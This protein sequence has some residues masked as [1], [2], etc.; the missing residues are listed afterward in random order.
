MEDFQKQHN[1]DKII[2]IIA[3]LFLFI[4]AASLTA[5]LPSLGSFNPNNPEAVANV[6][7]DDNCWILIAA[8]L[9]LLMTPGVAFFYGGAVYHKNVISTMYQSFIFCMGLISVLW[10]IIGFSL[11]FGEDAHHS[12]ILG[13]PK[14]YY[15]FNNVGAALNAALASNIS[16]TTF[17]MF[18]FMF[19]II[20][21]GLIAG[22]LAERVHFRSWML[23]VCFWYLVVCCPL[24]HITWS[25]NGILK[26]WGYI[27]FTGGILV[28]MASGYATLAG[29]LF[30]GPR[31]VL[32][33][34]PPNVPF[35]MLSTALFWFGW[36]GFNAG[37][38]LNVEPIASQVFLAT[39]TSGMVTWLLLDMYRGRKTS[40]VG[41]CNGI[42][43]GL[44]AII[45]GAGYVTAGAAMC[46]GIIATLICLCAGVGMKT[47]SS[48]DDSLDVFTVHGLSGTIGVILTGVFASSQVNPYGADGAIYGNP[49]LLA[50]HVA[51]VVL[52]IPPCIMIASYGCFW[53][54][55]L[56]SPMRVTA[57]EEL[58]GLDL[59]F[60]GESLHDSS[61]A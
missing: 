14:T 26:K 11:A 32:V 54:T 36:F 51:V 12:G 35:V 7:S 38:A 60:H 59:P 43:V 53:L 18:Q 13:Y 41:A 27:D 2:I 25:E 49:M 28:E 19:A 40:A 30:M 23:F 15:M 55:D 58:L 3:I 16:L 47:L 45:P 46:I 44:V 57:E 37:S 39:N 4:A 29:A 8:A 10:V 1:R 61:A 22:S 21:P 9:V 52:A 5:V 34:T 31:Q 56:I 17:S 6:K 48:I 50:K 20:T 24:A 42:V 33:H